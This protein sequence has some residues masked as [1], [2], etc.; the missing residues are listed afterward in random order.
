MA[1]PTE[2]LSDADDQLVERFAAQLRLRRGLRPASVSHT[3]RSNSG[4]AS[5]IKKRLT[6]SRKA[7]W[8]AVKVNSMAVTPALRLWAY[9]ARARQ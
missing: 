6:E 9:R 5:V 8:S 1:R 2:D 4:E 7:I 3:S